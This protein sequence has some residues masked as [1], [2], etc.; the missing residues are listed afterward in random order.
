MINRIKISLK[1]ILMM[2]NKYKRKIKIKTSK[3]I[4]KKEITINNILNQTSK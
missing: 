3:R 1:I 2:N 4:K